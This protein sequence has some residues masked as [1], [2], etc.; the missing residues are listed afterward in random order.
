MS[1]PTFNEFQRELQSR[2]IEGQQAYVFT[3]LYERLSHAAGEIEECAKAILA[4]A[5][6][7]QGF[8]G[9]HEATQSKLEQVLRGRRPDGIDVMSVA[10]DPGKD[11]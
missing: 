9:L 8:V 5:N 10:N 7:V 11:N 6:S 4:L 3:L 1:F 2:G